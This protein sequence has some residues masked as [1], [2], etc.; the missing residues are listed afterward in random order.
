MSLRRARLPISG[1][2][3]DGF[4]QLLVPIRI[5]DMGASPD[6]VTI[7][8]GRSIG[9]PAGCRGSRAARGVCIFHIGVGNANTD[10]VESDYYIF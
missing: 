9:L 2:Q 7:L 10:A 6:I 4:T 3:A 8:P 1:W 5:V